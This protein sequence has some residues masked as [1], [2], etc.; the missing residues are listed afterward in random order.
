M[1]ARNYSQKTMNTFPTLKG[2]AFRLRYPKGWRLGDS[3]LRENLGAILLPN[4]FHAQK[5]ENTVRRRFKDANAFRIYD[6][7]GSVFFCGSL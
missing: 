1:P 6:Q 5:C 7:D 3:P 4:G 2:V